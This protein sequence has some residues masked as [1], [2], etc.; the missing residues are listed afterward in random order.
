MQTFNNLKDVKLNNLPVWSSKPK[1][2]AYYEDTIND[3]VRRRYNATMRKQTSELRMFYVRLY[4]FIPN[5]KKCKTSEL[6]LS[7]K[8]IMQDIQKIKQEIQKYLTYEAKFYKFVN[9]VKEAISLEKI[10][11]AHEMCKKQENV[12]KVESV[13]YF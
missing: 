9:G 2:T 12:V 4:G 6:W 3:I 7:I 1:N 11:L 5:F 8:N 10:L 13:L